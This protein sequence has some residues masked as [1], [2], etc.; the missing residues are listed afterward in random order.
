MSANL[1]AVLKL[2]V[3]HMA[4]DGQEFPALGNGELRYTYTTKVAPNLPFV[5]IDR[6][7]G[8]LTWDSDH[9]EPRPALEAVARAHN[10]AVLMVRGRHCAR[11]CTVEM[12][13]PRLVAHTPIEL[14]W[15]VNGAGIEPIFF[16]TFAEDAV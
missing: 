7:Q 11:A 14:R 13:S 10:P 15:V 16:V 6:T 9:R 12:F 4:F 1:P 5:V 2:A 3:T 8:V